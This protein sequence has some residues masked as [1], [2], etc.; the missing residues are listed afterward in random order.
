MSLCSV[1]P[2]W[3]PLECEHASALYVGHEGP[4][5]RSPGSTVSPAA[6]SGTHPALFGLC[7]TRPRTGATINC[8]LNRF[9]GLGNTGRVQRVGFA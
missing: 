8:D 6:G 4:T 2:P 5:L 1:R 9:G 7:L 3:R